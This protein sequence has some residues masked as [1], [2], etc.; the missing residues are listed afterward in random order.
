MAHTLQKENPDQ[1]HPSGNMLSH[2]PSPTRTLDLD[3]TERIACLI[4]AKAISATL[5]HLPDVWWAP[6][7]DI[8]GFRAH[9]SEILIHLI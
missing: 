1:R 2:A 5:R 3:Q 6:F 8:R 4:G 7:A 9:E